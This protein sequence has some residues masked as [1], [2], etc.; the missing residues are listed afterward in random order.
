MDD[1]LI[2]YYSSVLFEAIIK[3][4]IQ[5]ARV[6]RHI[7]KLGAVLFT[8]KKPANMPLVRVGQTNIQVGSLMKYLGVIIDGSWN[9]RDYLRYI[10]SKATK[11]VRSLSRIM[12]NLK[13]PGERKRRLL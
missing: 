4:N 2:I 6:V 12:S 3:T 7:K 11:V 13:G 9:F 1:I 5:I 10:E 8:R